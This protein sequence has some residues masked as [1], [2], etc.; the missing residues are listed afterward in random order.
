MRI[1]DFIEKFY[2][3]NPFVISL[4][5]FRILFVIVFVGLLSFVFYLRYQNRNELQ[6]LNEKHQQ[7]QLIVSRYMSD[8]SQSDLNSDTYKFMQR[9]VQKY[10][11]ELKNIE[12]DIKQIKNV[13]FMK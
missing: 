3:A 2:P 4:S 13:W 11:E 9:K 12:K 5:T 8:M 10:Q 1:K 6:F 7:I